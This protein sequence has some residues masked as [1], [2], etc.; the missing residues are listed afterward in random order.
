MTRLDEPQEDIF[1]QL[2]DFKDIPGEEMVTPNSDGSYT[3][4]INARISHDRQLDALDHAMRHIKN[5]DFEKRDVQQIE[6][7]AHEPEKQMPQNPT[8]TSLPPREKKLRGKALTPEE[9][10]KKIRRKIR[11]YQREQKK[12]EEALRQYEEFRRQ[13][14]ENYDSFGLAE[15][16]YLYGKEL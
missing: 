4:L 6:A 8:V 9:F 13:L 16:G 1:V 11:Y 12:A 5:N 2:V 15:R 7:A 10:E 3:I 14:P